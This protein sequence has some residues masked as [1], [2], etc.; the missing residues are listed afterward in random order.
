VGRHVSPLILNN[1]F[2]FREI[3]CDPV[4]GRIIGW[5]KKHD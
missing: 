1:C 2:M 5:A 3:D 4:S